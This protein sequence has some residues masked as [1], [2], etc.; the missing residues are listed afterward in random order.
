MYDIVLIETPMPA[1]ESPKMYFGLGNLYLSAMLKKHGVNVY[2]ADCREGAQDLPRAKFYG[3]SCATPQITFAKQLAK[4]V[5][6]TTILGG[7]HATLLPEDC[8]EHFDYVVQGEGE[9]ALLDIIKGLIPKGIIKTSRITDLDDI[10]YPDWDV[11]DHV[12]SDTMYEG[13]RYGHGQLSMA[14]ITSRGCPF[15]CHFCGNMLNAPVTFRSVGNI[16]GEIYELNKRKVNHFRF[17]DDN[18]TLHPHFEQLCREMST[19]GIS[20]R[21][22]TRSD[23]MKTKI[24]GLLK[25]SGCEE[26]SVGV[27]SADDIVLIKNNKKESAKDHTRAIEI[28]KH[29][30]LKTK[31]YLMSGLPGETDRTIELTKQFMKTTKPDKWTLSTFSPYPGCEIFNHPEKFGVEIINPKWENWWNFVYNV[32]DLELPYREGYVHKLHGQTVEQMAQRHTDFYN[33]LIDERNWK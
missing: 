17:V 2:L 7:A 23:L 25:M 31:V 4:Q 3:F 33:W 8:R 19:F 24:A 30:G 28:M 10:P 32:R 15:K 13:E 12:F 22:H 26:C 1:L 20:Y 18:F 6:G 21:C 16:M 27:E 5:N 14:M 9:Y 11:A 29:E